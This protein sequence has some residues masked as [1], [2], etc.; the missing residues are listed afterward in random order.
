[1]AARLSS[2]FSKEQRQ[3]MV[4]EH[5]LRGKS[6]RQISKEVSC[7]LH[8]V[9]RDIAAIRDEWRRA[10]AEKMGDAEM[11]MELARVDGI[12]REAWAQWESSKK[13][14]VESHAST[15]VIIEQGPDGQSVRKPGKEKITRKTR[16]RNADPRYMDIVC[17]CVEQ[18]CKL[19]GL[20]NPAIHK[21]PPIDGNSAPKV[22]LDLSQLSDDEL[23]TLD[24]V[25]DRMMGIMPGGS[26]VN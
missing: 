6:F 18:R 17:W 26:S 20:I 21:A 10:R 22:I 11:L 4:L 9:H 13:E 25:R 23:I 19:L 24:K 16:I 3:N 15:E 12:E 8:T 14:E 2:I 7:S 5:Y 1:M